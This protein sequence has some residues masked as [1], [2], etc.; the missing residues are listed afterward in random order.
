MRSEQTIKIRRITR[1]LP[2]IE[3][4]KVSWP[5][6]VSIIILMICLLF[7][8]YELGQLEALNRISQCGT[9]ATVI[10]RGNDGVYTFHCLP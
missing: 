3:K 9:H 2:Y 7:L 1:P 8:T 10:S 6:V 4:H 5:L